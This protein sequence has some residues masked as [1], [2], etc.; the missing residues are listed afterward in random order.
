MLLRQQ[1]AH[2]AEH[3]PASSSEAGVIREV[4]GISSQ[5][6][7]ATERVDRATG[8]GRRL[9]AGEAAEAAAAVRQETDEQEVPED[10]SSATPC[11]MASAFM[12]CLNEQMSELRYGTGGECHDY[13]GPGQTGLPYRMQCAARGVFTCVATCL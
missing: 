7:E 2:H 12:R 10:W 6:W 1:A 5:L 13:C 11:E 9:G 8:I 3:T 4:G